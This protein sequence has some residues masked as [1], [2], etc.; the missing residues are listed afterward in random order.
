MGLGHDFIGR[1]IPRQLISS[2]DAWKL[3]VWDFIP[4]IIWEQCIIKLLIFC[5]FCDSWK[6][7]KVFTI[8]SSSLAANAGTCHGGGML[9][10]YRYAYEKGI[11][12]ETCNNYQ[13]KDQSCT[14]FNQCGTCTWFKKCHVVQNYTRWKAEQYGMFIRSRWPSTFIFKI[15]I[16]I[17]IKIAIKRNMGVP[18][19]SYFGPLFFIQ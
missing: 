15:Y 9:G 6:I 17:A 16:A 4:Q 19:G 8:Y 14:P 18:Q 1:D 12:D 5:K 7:L 3:H 11:P 10:V 13:A 2:S